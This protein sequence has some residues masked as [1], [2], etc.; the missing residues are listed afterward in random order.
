MTLSLPTGSSRT[1]YLL[2]FVLLATALVYMQ[3]LSFQF[4]YDDEPQIVTNPRVHSFRYVPNYFAENVWAHEGDRR[5]YFR[6]IFLLALLLQYKLFGVHVWGWH[7]VSIAWHLVATWL[8]F[9]FAR[10]M[11]PKEEESDDTALIAA[12]L[13]GLAP[14]HVEVVVWA[15]AISD[16]MIAV[17]VTASFLLYLRWRDEGRVRFLIA[18]LVS[19]ALGLGTKEPAITMVG[20]LAAYELLYRRKG[21]S[22]RWPLLGVMLFAFTG[23]VYL[24]WRT[25]VLHALGYRTL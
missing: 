25:Y 1:Q 6:S 17:F 24:A 10:R 4:C 3:S 12:L 13:F 5:N 23:F 9:L 16:S 15:S 21:E 18:S 19:F 7:L 14:V 11:L 22:I 2:A 20:V 8:V